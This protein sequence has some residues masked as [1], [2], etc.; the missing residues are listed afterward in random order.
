VSSPT[1]MSYTPMWRLTTSGAPVFIGANRAVTV[2]ALLFKRL[3]LDPALMSNPFVA[4]LIDIV[5]IVIY[6]N[7]A[8]QLL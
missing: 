6:L 2:S 5:G 3:G 1:G 7:V 8:I 4:G